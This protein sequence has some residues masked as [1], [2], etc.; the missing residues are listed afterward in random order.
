MSSSSPSL[1]VLRIQSEN[2]CERLFS[3]QGYQRTSL[4][5][6]ARLRAMRRWNAQLAAKPHPKLFP[7]TESDCAAVQ[8]QM[9]ALKG[10]GR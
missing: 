3:R 1:R 7:Y 9:A 5:C 10:A 4:Q 2:L 6:R 8:E